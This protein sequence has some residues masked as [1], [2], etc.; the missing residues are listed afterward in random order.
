MTAPRVPQAPY[1]Y[2]ST[3]IARKA[4]KA[5]CDAPFGCVMMVSALIGV[6][7]AQLTMP[8]VLPLIKHVLCALIPACDPLQHLP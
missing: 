2:H 1:E 8:F 5:F 7:I 3:G 4:M 6:A